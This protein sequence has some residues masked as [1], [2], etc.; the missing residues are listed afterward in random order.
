[1]KSE[2][3][4][5]E[6][7]SYDG[8]LDR[9]GGEKGELEEAKRDL[10]VA[11]L[12]ENELARIIL[13]QGE[14]IRAVEEERNT[15]EATLKIAPDRVTDPDWPEREQR[16]L[17]WMIDG[18]KEDPRGLEATVLAMLHKHAT[19]AI[20]AMVRLER[21][22]PAVK[23][24]VTLQRPEAWTQAFSAMLQPSEDFNLLA[25][26]VDALTPEDRA[27]AEGEE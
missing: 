13:R 22:R 20:D 10:R 2:L 26:A 19:V 9:E 15:L 25:R 16:A 21:V 5:V 14:R 8:T 23:A 3:D 4:E 27:W 24:A 1:M 6:L 11:H 7:A 12:A 18:A 17:R